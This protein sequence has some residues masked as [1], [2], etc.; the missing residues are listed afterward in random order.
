MDQ[1][2]IDFAR[3]QHQPASAP[4]DMAATTP[5]TG[6]SPQPSSSLPSLISFRAYILRT[7]VR[8]DVVMDGLMKTRPCRF[9]KIRQGRFSFH[10]CFIFCVCWESRADVL[11]RYCRWHEQGT[12][13]PS[14]G[15]CSSSFSSTRCSFAEDK[16]CPISHQRSLRVPPPYHTHSIRSLPLL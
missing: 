11:G 13:Y 4:I 15:D 1:A 10:S 8:D 5:K 2:K 16:G 3:H 14:S 6:A 9:C 12:C 7:R